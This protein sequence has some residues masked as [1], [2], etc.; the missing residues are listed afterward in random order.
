MNDDLEG[1]QS[2]E[3]NFFSYL[4]TTTA[5]GGDNV[6]GSK[7]CDLV[8]LNSLLNTLALYLSERDNHKHQ[9]E[10]KEITY[11]E[12]RKVM[13]VDLNPNKSRVCYRKDPNILKVG[14]T[15]LAASL[16]VILIKLLE[17]QNE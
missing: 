12:L 9:F 1:D 15:E 7:E 6:N 3:A 17:I 16:A 10:F 11:E 2:K 13:S 4:F 14:A 5:D 8:N